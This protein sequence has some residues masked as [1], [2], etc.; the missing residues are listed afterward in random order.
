[1]DFERFSNNS[2]EKWQLKASK[3]KYHFF[4]PKKESKKYNT[5]NSIMAKW[6]VRHDTLHVV[7]D[8]AEAW[9]DNGVAHLLDRNQRRDGGKTMVNDV[10][11]VMRESAPKDITRWFHFKNVKKI[12][13]TWRD[14]PIWPIF[15][16]WVG[17]C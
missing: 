8:W 7:M 3:V 15:F 10:M 13:S 6:L 14:D 17:T 9:R 5:P 12:T 11:D 1:M 4:Q 2:C 16:N